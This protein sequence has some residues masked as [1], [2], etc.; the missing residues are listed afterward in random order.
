VTLW[1]RAEDSGS[2][3]RPGS[4]ILKNVG[5]H[6]PVPSRHAGAL[7]DQVPRS[8]A[9]IS[10]PRAKSCRGDPGPGCDVESPRSE[11]ERADGI[12]GDGGQIEMPCLSW[13]PAGLATLLA[14]AGHPVAREVDQCGLGYEH[15]AESSRPVRRRGGGRPSRRPRAHRS[16]QTTPG[17][18]RCGPPRAMS[19]RSQRVR[20]S[21]GWPGSASD[22]IRGI[23]RGSLST[24]TQVREVSATWPG[25]CSPG[26]VS[27]QPMCL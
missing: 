22:R 25:R 8:S 18:G 15:R 27:A 3:G 7:G 21:I 1:T 23:V 13:L 19:A 24:R 14:V 6:R 17:D 5:R 26:C 12:S 16:L 11:V 9:A 10:T 2:R 20:P 4:R